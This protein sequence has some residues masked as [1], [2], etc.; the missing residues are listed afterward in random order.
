MTTK[1]T[2][3]GGMGATAIGLLALRHTAVRSTKPAIPLLEL[4]PGYRGGAGSPLLLIHGVSA[5]WHAWSPLLPYLEP[6][7]DVLAPT[8][9]GHGGA[10]PFDLHVPPSVEGLADGIEAEL[11]RAGFSSVHVAGNSLGG[12]IAIELARRG[13]ARSLV[14]LSPAGACRSQ[15]R[16]AATA[17][18]IRL[19]V[20]GLSRFSAHADAIASRPLLRWLLLSSQVAHPSRVRPEWL[21]AS[22]R[23][24]AVAP[25]VDELLRDLPQR[26]VEPLSAG[27]GYPIRVVWPEHDRVLPFE[28]FGAPM[29]E[30]IP[31]ADVV[32]IPG[33]GHVPMS[34]DPAAISKLILDVTRLVDVPALPLHQNDYGR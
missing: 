26:R 27:H 15:R 23:A 31:D 14:L 6:H 4:T 25:A 17:S 18:A 3:I 11:D 32:R 29:L 2:V 30:R 33:V 5:T 19:S 10:S 20:K 12:W 22:V 16:M 8:L 1:A 9:L 28:H 34:D 24:A 7:H 21:A 13:R